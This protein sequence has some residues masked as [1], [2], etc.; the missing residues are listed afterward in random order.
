MN[1]IHS[2]NRMIYGIVY[3]KSVSVKCAWTALSREILENGTPI[4]RDTCRD[5]SRAF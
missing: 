4:G 3:N 2:Q 1:D 5:V